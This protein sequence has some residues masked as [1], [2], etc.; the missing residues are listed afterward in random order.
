MYLRRKARLAASSLFS[1]MLAVSMVVPAPALGYLSQHAE[2]SD[3]SDYSSTYEGPGYEEGRILVAFKKETSLKG[4]RSAIASADTV[5][6]AIDGGTYSK[7]NKM[8]LIDLE[9]G[10]DVTDA[11]DELSE[12]P[13]VEYVQ[14][15]YL[16]EVLDTRQS[17]YS[18]VASV[19]ETQV[20]GTNDPLRFKQ[21]YL[22][23]VGAY[24]AWDY[25]KADGSVTV[26]VLDTGIDMDHV[27]LQDN[28]VA[29]YD[30]TGDSRTDGSES[31][32]DESPDDL[33]GHGSHVAG[34][35]AGA[36]NNGYGISGVSYNANIMP[37]RVCYWSDY[38][39][40]F[41][42]TSADLASAYRYILSVA[43]R[44][45]NGDGT[46]GTYAQEFN[47]RVANMSLGALSETGSQITDKDDLAVYDLV[48]RAT[49]AGV[50]TVCAAGNESSD[51]YSFPSDHDSCV[52]VIA[53]DENDK[54]AS[55]SNYG[56]DKD[57]S[58][59]GTAM[60]STVPDVYNESHATTSIRDGEGKLNYYAEMQGTSMASPLVA[61]IAA[62][63]FAANP[64]LT[65][66]KVADI[67]YATATDLGERGKDDQFGYGKVN[68]AA[69]VQAAT[70]IAV[71]GIED[72]PSQAIAKEP[73]KISASVV[74]SDASKKDIEYSVVDA[75][76][77]GAV[78]NGDVFVAQTAGAATVRAMIANGGVNGVDFAKV[79]T[80]E[81]APEQ[82]PDPDPAPDP[83]PQPVPDP[84]GDDSSSDDVV[85]PGVQSISVSGL[86]KRYAYTGKAIVPGISVKLNGVRLKPGEDYVVTLKNNVD[87]G[88]AYL[89][90]TLLGNT[91]GSARVPF[92]IVAPSVGKS[93]IAKVKGK[94]RAVA[95]KISNS[96]RKLTSGYQ[97]R[98][99]TKKSMKKA[100]SLSVKTAKATSKTI[101]RL[102]KS[103]RY[104]FQVRSYRTVGSKRFAS[105]WSS[106]VSAKT[107]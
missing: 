105:T 77:T 78:V 25:A 54:R 93:L 59:P 2:V 104:Y 88:T 5:D 56:S 66:E 51:E 91:T 47:V 73:L 8:V 24:Q 28:I 84:S 65:P 29:P 10:C 11:I 52:S 21:W 18:N 72:L 87:I 22:N 55:F 36:T 50:L 39:N 82:K 106:A 83:D 26:A 41:V 95:L 58:A 13:R 61:G 69:A 43:P 75:G 15:N 85:V 67:L 107:K 30:V 97:I 27:D 7:S 101:K 96:N 37:L 80:I 100:K 99:S 9:E 17:S 6:D 89:T 74:P 62:L 38:A 63:V 86:A 64:N 98:Y 16:Y 60:F 3:A 42:A 12:D 76:M 57:I 92:Q 49:R 40:N 90:L 102:K 35:A 44:D 14:P 23:S 70:G 94:K 53:L 71:T 45:Y 19:V 103:K 79:F 4:A 1:A 32:P 20:T 34:I 68:V 33:A 46:I 81:V 48:D 31:I